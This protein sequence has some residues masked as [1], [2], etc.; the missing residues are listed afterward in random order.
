M[1]I[2]QIITDYI[3]NSILTTQG[4]MVVRGVGVPERLASV[5]IGQVLKS[6]GAGVQPAWG[7][8]G[9]GDMQFETGNLARNSSGDEVISGLSFAPKLV[10]FFSAD[11]AVSDT[12]SIGV[13]NGTKHACLQGINDGS[14]TIPSQSDSIWIGN[15]A[16]TYIHGSITALTSDGFTITFVLVNAITASVYWFAI[17]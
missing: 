9:M 6:Q 1:D 17:G 3:R 11:Q 14:D 15:P 5:A 8:P 4:D 16:G 10:F 2:E 12:W 13:D 7:L